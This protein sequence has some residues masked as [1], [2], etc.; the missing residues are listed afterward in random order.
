MSQIEKIVAYEN[1]ELSDQEIVDLFQELI[2]SG[3]VWKLQGHYGRVAKT[4]LNNGYCKLPKG[5]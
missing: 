5:E 2:D 4:L 3:L 1:G